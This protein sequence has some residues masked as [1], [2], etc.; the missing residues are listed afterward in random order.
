MSPSSPFTPIVSVVDFH[1]ARGPEVE[2]WFGVPDGTD[3]AEDNDWT[4]LPFLALS[5]GAHL[6][7]EDFSYFTLVHK[8]EPPRSLFGISCTRQIDASELLNKSPDVTR[9]AVQKAVVVITDNPSSLSTIREKQ[10]IVTKAWFAQKDFTDCE[11]LQGFQRSLAAGIEDQDNESDNLL[12]LSLREIIHTFKWQ[13]LV[14]VKCLLL[15]PKMLFFGTQC[16]KVCLLQ[17]SLLSLIPGLL[18]ALQDCADPAM[19]TY[20][21]TLAKSTS[22]R[23][24]DRQSLLSYM[25]LPL[26]I[27][28]KGS[29]FGPYTPLQQLDTL[30][31]QNTKS[32]V[33][34]STNSLLLHQKDRYADV[35]VNLDDNTVSIFS[36]SLRSALT[37]S[38]ADRRWIDFLTQ[39]V[40]NTWDPQN[41]SRPSHMGYSGSEEFIRLQFEEYLLA[42]L[43][44]IKYHGYAFSHSYD[45]KAL[46]TD[47]EGDPSLEFSSEFTTA[48]TQS[49]NYKLFDRVTDS[50]LFDVIEPR[51]PCA[52][53]LTID[54]VQRRLAQQVQEL[55]LDERWRGGREVIGKRFAEGQKRIGGF[56]TGVWADVEAMRE[57]QRKK[58]AAAAAAAASDSTKE[59]AHDTTAA[60]TNKS[61]V[62]TDAPKGNQFQR[63]DLSAAGAQVSAA[64]A[65]AG[66]YLSSWGAWAAEKRRTAW[67]SSTDTSPTEPQLERRTSELMITDLARRDPFAAAAASGTRGRNQSPEKKL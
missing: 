46:L 57:A 61:P 32:Y 27:F 45:S 14:L 4:L 62:K 37:L 50:H 53:G 28:G 63:P 12:S 5:D 13:T 15:Q 41:P 26:Q 17:F 51:H 3:P 36:T 49:E 38:T 16:E 64:S 6:S 8:S 40:N 31:D 20:G 25:G 19:D 52:G 47:V 2:K 56:V 43:S 1:H 11:I 30:A 23:T 55:H 54:D 66:A 44:S 29:L 34:G 35:L 58:A 24:S 39:T 21:A 65:R 18:R 22:L 67:G 59:G 9:S 60:A 7:I 48:W 42:L 10:S 33:V